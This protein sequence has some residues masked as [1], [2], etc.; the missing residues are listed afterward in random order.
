MY[1]LFGSVYDF[2]YHNKS[3]NPDLELEKF[4][5][6]QCGWIRL[7]TQFSMGITI[8][9]LQ[10]LFFYGVKRYHYE[11]SIGIRELSERIFL[12]FFNGPFSTDTEILVNN[13]H[14]L[15]EVYAGETV[16]TFQAINFSSYDYRS[17]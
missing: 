10:K 15:D 14:P 13:M 12:D 7:F 11:K 8:T 6:N 5:I 16:P 17:T 3:R 1:K 4:C 2:D 9:N